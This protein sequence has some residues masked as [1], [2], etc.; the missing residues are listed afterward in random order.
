V[1]YFTGNRSGPAAWRVVQKPAEFDF[2]GVPAKRLV[3]EFGA[4]AE[5][6]RKEVVVVRRGQRTYIFTT[7]TSPTDVPTRDAVRAALERISWKPR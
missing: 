6:Q 5:A 1:E 2:G 3:L 4:G 7:I